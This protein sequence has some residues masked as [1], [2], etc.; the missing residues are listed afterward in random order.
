MEELLKLLD[1]TVVYKSHEIENDVITMRAESSK[2]NGIC[3]YCG[4]ESDKVHSHYVRILKDLPISGM[5]TRLALRLRKFYCRNPEC[6]YKTFAEHHPFFEQRNKA[7]KRLRSEILRVALSQ[8]SV[9]A[10]KF[11]REHVAD[12]G[13]S[14]ICNML[15]K[16]RDAD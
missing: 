1:E 4:I 8:S 14:S 11:L 5:K 3:P 9:S 6:T 16:I 7:T 2:V 13:K 15:K 12:V 10:A